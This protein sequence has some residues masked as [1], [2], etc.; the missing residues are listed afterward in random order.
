[1]SS[2]PMLTTFPA[3]FVAILPFTLAQEAPYP[4]QWDNPKNFSNDPRD[5]GGATM[6]GIIQSEYNFWRTMW[7]LPRQSVKLISEQEGDNI[8]YYGYYLPYCPELQAG[9]DLSFFD[10]AVNEGPMR[11]LQI[12]Q[13]TLGIASDGAWGPITDAAVKAIKDT[14]NIINSFTAR[15]H[16]VYENT[17]GYTS[18]GVDWERRTTEIGQASLKMVYNPVDSE[19]KMTTQAQIQA[20]ADALK[21]YAEGQTW[22]AMFAPQSA[23][24]TGA[25]DMLAAAD[26]AT[27]Q[28]PTGR[29]AAAM[30]KLQAD[31]AA[32]GYA[33]LMTAQQCHDAAAVTL[34]AANKTTA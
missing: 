8:Y 21:A 12:L 11:A 28:S 6:E 20:A 13:F 30:A 4:S 5:P 29:Q 3:R 18:F 25:T 19:V 10:V 2:F 22:E 15:R 7:G 31:I 32:A 34:A 1:M 26:A 16:V 33:N 9:L 24:T 14:T 27:D 17:G 23:W